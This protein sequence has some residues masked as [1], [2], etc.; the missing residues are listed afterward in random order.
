MD[1]VTPGL[2]QHYK[3]GKYRVLFTGTHSETHEPLVV[4]L[5]LET[6]EVWVR[7]ETM[8]HDRVT[9]PDGTSRPRFEPIEEVLVRHSIS[10][11]LAR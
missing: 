8:W 3:G 1:A 6:G 2:Y 10:S 9:G 7:P 11:N 5:S 4:Y